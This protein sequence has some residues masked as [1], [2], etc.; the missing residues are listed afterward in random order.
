MT[1]STAHEPQDP[2]ALPGATDDPAAL[3]TAVVGVVGINLL[4]ATVLLLYI[5]FTSESSAE[6]A[7]KADVPNTALERYRADQAA[8]LGTYDWVDKEQ[9]V[10]A[11]PIARAVELVTTELNGTAVPANPGGE[12]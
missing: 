4:I 11:I 5:V 12:Q 10:V 2:R 7:R 8:L 9:K 6:K 1:T 3:P